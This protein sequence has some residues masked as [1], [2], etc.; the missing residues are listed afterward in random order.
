M[1]SIINGGHQIITPI[2]TSPAFLEQVYTLA[3][4]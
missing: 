4:S 1:S 2:V 3:T